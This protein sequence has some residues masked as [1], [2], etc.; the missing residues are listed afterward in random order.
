MGK[1]PTK[2]PRLTLS[3]SKSFHTLPGV[4]RMRELNQQSPACPMV[5]LLEKSVKRDL[6]GLW[7]CE[8]CREERGHLEVVLIEESQSFSP[9]DVLFLSN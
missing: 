4:S 7:V 5:N 3:L 6:F 1:I 8:L 9:G 2:Q